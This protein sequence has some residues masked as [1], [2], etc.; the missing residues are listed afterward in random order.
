[1]RTHPVLDACV[2]RGVRLGLDRIRA[3]L[4]AMGEPHRAVPV[5]HVA[6]TNGKGSVCTMTSAA[7][8]CSGM[9]VGTYLSP[10]VENINERVRL[11]GE[12]V[13]DGLLND[14]IEA[15]ERASSTYFEAM[16]TPSA[17]LTTLSS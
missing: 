9:R 7:L 16:G 10:H 4:T 15:V 12:P 1:M 3:F 8:R 13:S 5:V 17:G 14:A 2:A 6:G 11:D